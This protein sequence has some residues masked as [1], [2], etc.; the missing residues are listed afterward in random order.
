MAEGSLRERL[1]RL[2]RGP[3]SLPPANDLER[4]EDS[5]LLA[6]QGGLS[7]KQR[8]ERLV[9]AATRAERRRG[10]TASIEDLVP[11]QRVTNERGE[12][13][14]VEDSVH[15]D[16][17][18][19]ELPL[20]RIRSVRPGSVGILAAEPS[21]DSFDLSGAAFIDTETTGLAGGTGTAAFLIG[22][23]YVEDDRF[24]V[25]QFLMRD[26]HE[27]AALLRG[28]AEELA[29]FAQIVT[30]NGKIFDVPLLESRYRLNRERYPLEQA[31][32]LDLLHPAR[33]LWKMRLESCRLQ[34]LESALLG[35]RR[36]G[37]VPG[38][39]IPRIYFD[40]VRSRDASALPQVLEHN[41]LDIVSLAALAVLACQWVEDSWAEDPRDVYSL[42]R[43]FERAEMYELSDA[44]YR[45]LVDD[46]A[47]VRTVRVPSLLALAT[48][49]KRAGDLATAVE[50]WEQ[51]AEAG[52]CLAL[53]ELAVHH[54]HRSRDLSAALLTVDR[55]LTRFD[56]NGEP[57]ARWVA[58][59]FRRR[60]ERLMTKLQRH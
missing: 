3:A 8:L 11:G 47:A 18:H 51:A 1:Q 49:A 38:E 10:R 60:R 31:L 45:R 55:A 30:F 27:E 56:G 46:A 20:A 33:R 32:H 43:V 19:G 42:A 4:L 54:E 29:R 21:L 40:Y 15:L 14:L 36:Y 2:R 13:F 52:D 12:F 48:R 35:V 25:R 58:E 28:L 5:F 26:Y 24:R 7:L 22:V 44:H 39:E 50:L 9:S 17:G 57:A 41:R 59:D 6:P 37:D 16:R 53:R 34:S 23:G